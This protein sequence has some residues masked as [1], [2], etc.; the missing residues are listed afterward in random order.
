MTYLT[1]EQ[2]QAAKFSGVSEETYAKELQRLNNEK[3]NGWRQN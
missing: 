1:P 2:K 3:A